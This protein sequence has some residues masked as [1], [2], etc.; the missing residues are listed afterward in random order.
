MLSCAEVEAFDMEDQQFTI[1]KILFSKASVYS[2]TV[3]T[4]FIIC[5]S[6]PM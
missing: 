2:Y 1:L 4:L 3:D 5:K 6:K